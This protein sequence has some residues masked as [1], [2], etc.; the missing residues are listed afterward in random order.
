MKT[1]AI[2]YHDSL[3][4]SRSNNDSPSAQSLDSPMRSTS[5]VSP[6]AVT[7][8]G[9]LP[10]GSVTSSSHRSPPGRSSSGHIQTS[11]SYARAASG[12][13]PT[14]HHSVDT[15]LPP[16]T[17]SHSHHSSH[18]QQSLDS[19][20]TYF[21][22]SSQYSNANGPGPG[23]AIQTNGMQMYPNGETMISP[24]GTMGFGPGT[25]SGSE[26]VTSW[27]ASVG[28]GQSEWARFLNAV[29]GPTGVM[30]S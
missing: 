19:P 5:I 17:S 1:L 4:S 20:T 16:S 26:E 9:G 3:G 10:N 18:M 22:H 11:T 29:Q 7:G 6:H 13:H 15:M 12:V 30:G 14:R 25:G 27:G 21:P 8:R 23:P 24:Q 28:I 2:P